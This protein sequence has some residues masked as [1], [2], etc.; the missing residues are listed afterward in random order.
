MGILKSKERGIQKRY[1]EIRE[2]HAMRNKIFVPEFLQS[3]WISFIWP[4]SY[5][6]REV[7]KMWEFKHFH[8]WRSATKYTLLRFWCG[9]HKTTW[10]CK[11]AKLSWRKPVLGQRQL[12]SYYADLEEWLWEGSQWSMGL[13]K[14]PIWA[15]NWHLYHWTLHHPIT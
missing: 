6:H 1:M 12:N 3:N 2:S 9:L 4:W 15:S 11:R 14:Y 10:P 5:E 13:R 8:A 7:S